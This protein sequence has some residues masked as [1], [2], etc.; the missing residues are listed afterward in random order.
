MRA[1]GRKP[2]GRRR[3]SRKQQRDGLQRC[4]G[5][6]HDLTTG[7]EYAIL[8]DSMDTEQLLVLP[9]REL[10]A[11]LSIEACDPLHLPRAPQWMN[12]EVR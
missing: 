6:F 2:A 8:A 12:K 3:R 9:T 10:R 1:A 7:V 5:I 11:T 4:G